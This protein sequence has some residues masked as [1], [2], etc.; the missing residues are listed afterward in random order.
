[1]FVLSFEVCDDGCVRESRYVTERAAWTAKLV[2]RPGQ[3]GGK[4]DVATM[5][6]PVTA[7]VIPAREP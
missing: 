7:D 2:K 1:M 4:Y 5:R 3:P 6:N